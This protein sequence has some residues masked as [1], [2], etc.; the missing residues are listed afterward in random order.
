MRVS[1]PTCLQMEATE[2]GAAALASVLEYHG[3]YV[4][5]SRLRAECGVSRDGS[6]ASNILR[7]ARRFGFDAR[8]QRLEPAD[9]RAIEPPFIVHWNLNHFV[10][11]DGFDPRR[12]YL[13]D[14][15]SGPRA[16]STREFDESFT[17]IVLTFEKT[18]EFVASGRR[19]SLAK[20]LF[21]RAAG[22]GRALTLIV[23]CGV[24][25]VVPSLLIPVFSKVFVDSVLVANKRDWLPPLL[26]GMATAAALRGT[27]LALQRTQL[28]RVL[29]RLSV[30]MTSTFL[31]HVLRLPVPFFY[32]RSPGDLAS[33]TRRN[34]AVASLLS[35]RVSS[36]VLDLFQ[37]V[38]YGALMLYFDRLLSAVGFVS[39]LC[40][41]GLLLLAGRVRTDSSRRVA[42][43]SGKIQ[44]IG[45]E[46]LQAIETIK[47]AGSEADFFATWAGHQAQLVAAR[48]ALARREQALHVAGSALSTISDVVLLGLG[49]LRVMDG[50]LSVGT[51]VAL[52]SLMN[53][54]LGPIENLTSFGA[55][56]QQLRGDVERLDDVLGNERESG[57]SAE[58]P[59]TIEPR[60][61]HGS[62]ELRD[63]SFS[64]LPFA[65][66]LVERLSLQ[67]APGQRVALVGGTGSGKSTVAKLVT[68]LYTPQEGKILFDG[69]DRRKLPRA[70]LTR[71]V[72]MVDQDIV[73][74]EG[75]VRDNLTLWDDT[76][77]EADIVRAA[78]DACIHEDIARLQGGYDAKVTEGGFNFSGGQRQ[79]LEI[80]RAL[81]RQPALLV[82]DEATS[83][84]DA[85]TERRVDENLRKRGCSCLIIA[86]RLSTIRDCDEIIVLER[87]QAVQRGSH[88]RLLG[89]AGPYRDLI[90][91]S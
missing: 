76:V 52:Q 44:G 21:S 83:A 80:A 24:L 75:S 4:P 42:Q 81:V 47:A 31:W 67:I 23:L 51:L 55:A 91:A 13:N 19:P 30:T 50:A 22:S 79:R 56:L 40:H 41:M 37:V 8:G 33:R 34:D 73:L 20:A 58:L 27:L 15:A 77:P 7:A 9:L 14:P 72:A 11:V 18:P 48:Q 28:Q 68:G 39:A 71:S 38:F 43:A 82:L 60:R 26:V 29:T 90:S 88:E 63:V 59:S 64:Y 46:G 12:V 45:A 87:G 65:A 36:A 16:V 17:G 3:S 2:C 54:F 5:L 10:V 35:S 6:K 84:L 74:F 25:S 89:E 85:D 1:T 49:A 32:A 61:L 62:L 86:H 69:R 53:S 57:V 78:Q 66:P 70:A